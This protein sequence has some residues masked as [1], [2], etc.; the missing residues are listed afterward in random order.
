[1]SNELHHEQICFFHTRKDTGQLCGKCL[2][3][4]DR[5]ESFA[6]NACLCQTG[7]KALR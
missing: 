2:F 5:V 3:A 1:M 6:V 4:S 7:W